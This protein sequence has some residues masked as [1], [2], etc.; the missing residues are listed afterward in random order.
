MKTQTERANVLLSADLR[1][2]AQI[3]KIAKTFPPGIHKEFGKSKG[4]STLRL[5]EYN[6]LEL[7]PQS[8]YLID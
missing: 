5:Q 4:T 7:N 2:Q 3:K 1:V 6:T 8:V